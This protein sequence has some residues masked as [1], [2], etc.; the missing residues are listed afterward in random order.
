MNVSIVITTYNY[1]SYLEECIDSCLEQDCLD[2]EY[3]V[4]VVDDGST[5][6]TPEILEKQKYH[7]VRIYRIENCGVEKAS[8]FGFAKAQGDYIVRVDADDKLCS[9]YLRSIWPHVNDE[10]G[11]YYPDYLVI[12]ADGIAIEKIILPEF[13]PAEIRAR[14]DFLATGT[15]YSAKLLA[16]LGGYSTTVRNCGLENYE[17]ILRLIKSGIV[18]KHISDCLFS[19]RRHSL[20]ISETKKDQIIRNGQIMFKQMN[21]GTYTANVYHPYKLNVTSK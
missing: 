12:N 3:E 17:L 8:N 13:R 9:N 7:K 11:F 10:F 6:R 16:K 2:L 19:Y 21:L 1:S 15:L 18:G 20:N 5:D 14:G 4:I